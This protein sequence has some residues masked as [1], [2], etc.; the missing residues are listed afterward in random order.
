MAKSIGDAARVIQ[1]GTNTIA[2]PEGSRSQTGELGK[3]YGG[4][5][6]L[7]LRTGV[8]LTPISLEGS[9]RVIAPMTA[10]VNPGVILRI[11]IDRPI[12]LSAYSKADRQR[13]MT[14][15]FKS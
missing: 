7:A 12:D 1:N 8:P 3:F 6:T 2:F 15:S 13:L 14:M 9:Y 4:V 11:K 10:R 5:F